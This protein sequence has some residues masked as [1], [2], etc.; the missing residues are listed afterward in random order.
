MFSAKEREYLNYPE[1][2]NAAYA[3]KL[4]NSIKKK[5]ITMNYDLSLLLLDN[6]GID[7]C[8][9]TKNQ[10][11]SLPELL[12]KTKEMLNLTVFNKSMESEKDPTT[13]KIIKERW[14]LWNKNGKPYRK[15]EKE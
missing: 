7:I 12:H 15:E 4:K 13:G 6:D 10:K 14:V 11:D 3:A 1:R 9:S 2:F 8:N 5:I